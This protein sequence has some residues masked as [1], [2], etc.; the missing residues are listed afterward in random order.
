MSFV[1]ERENTLSGDEYRLRIIEEIMDT[2]K[3]YN[4]SLDTCIQYYYKR[5]TEQ[6]PPIIPKSQTE[7]IFLYFDEIANVNKSFYLE[8]Q[9]AK[10]SSTLSRS[11]GKIFQ[12]YI[13]YF[14]V[15]YQYLGNTGPSQQAV[16]TI[17]T[18]KKIEDFLD[19]V[20]LAIPNKSNQ[21]DLQGFLIMPVQRLPRY[22]L[23]LTDLVKRT[24]ETYDDYTNIKQA[25]TEMKKLTDSANRAIVSTERR[26]VLFALEKRISGFSGKLVEPQRYFIKEGNL[27][28]V[29]RKK[30]KPRHFILFNDIFLYGMGDEAATKVSQVTEVF[31]V[32]VK[33]VPQQNAFEILTDQKSFVVYASNKEE[34]ESWMTEI[35]KA[36]EEATRALKTRNKMNDSFIK[37]PFVPDNTVTLC[38]TCNTQFGIW[39]RRHHC[40]FCGKCVC[41]GCTKM[42]VPLPPLMTLERACPGCV[43]RLLLSARP[44]EKRDK[45]NSE[46]YGSV[47]GLS[48]T[49]PLV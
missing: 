20:R 4:E 21:L 46:I 27:R 3:T 47:S 44:V 24:P 35:T 32:F 48:S 6:S 10:E 12:N 16:Q 11:I 14:R 5:I 36:N 19:D 42:R 37:P 34:K 1:K 2:E 22:T 25:L 40:R 17:S 31:S 28:K 13:P 33:D 29:C 23:L 15:Y 41:D 18:S 38:M 26:R 9:N 39:T 45:I 49:P 30:I 7:T 8:L 43:D